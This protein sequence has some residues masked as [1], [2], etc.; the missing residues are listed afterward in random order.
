MWSAGVIIFILL[1]GYAPFD[2]DNDAVLYQKI[3]RGD[4]D[5]ND[6]AWNLLSPASR[7]FVVSLLFCLYAVCEHP[8]DSWSL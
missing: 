3:R 7:D 1:C 2:D 6:A 4:I 8:S 5:K